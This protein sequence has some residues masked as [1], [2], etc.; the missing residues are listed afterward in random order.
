MK[1]S[2]SSLLILSL[3]IVLTFLIL[4][5]KFLGVFITLVLISIL[6]FIGSSDVN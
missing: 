6:A 3:M 1:N 4:C 5:I 2:E